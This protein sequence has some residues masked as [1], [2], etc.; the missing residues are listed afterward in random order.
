MNERI[1]ANEDDFDLMEVN[2]WTLQ[3][4]S[5]IYEYSALFST[6]M[7]IKWD[8]RIYVDLYAGTGKVITK[9]SQKVLYGSP[10]LAMEVKDKFDKYI[11]CEKDKKN[12]KSLK[13]RVENF[14]SDLDVT[15]IHGDCN[16]KIETVFNLIPKP[17]IGNSVLTFCFIDPFKF[18]IQFNT[19]KVLSKYY[20]DFLMLFATDMDL[21]RNF[22]DHYVKKDHE[23]LDIFFGDEIWR[24]EWQ[25]ASII[26]KKLN[27]FVAEEFTKRMV[28]LGYSNESIENYI[29]I[30]NSKKNRIYYL[31]LYSRNKKAFEF[32]NKVVA[33]NNEPGLFD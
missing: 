18:D 23:R 21:K 14:Y 20:V 6:G 10:L 2:E 7:K 32:W 26:G 28:R 4:N 5:I 33:R 30:E 27:R 9:E 25:Q 29:P 24:D 16:E 31:A 1:I 17:S 3:K 11:L 22:K 19:I 15:V 13:S 12:Y 8:H